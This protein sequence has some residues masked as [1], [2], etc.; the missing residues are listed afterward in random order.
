MKATVPAES[1]SF[2]FIFN[3][4]DALWQSSEPCQVA[5]AP[6]FAMYLFII[7]IAILYSPKCPNYLENEKK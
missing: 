4:I 5:A 2:Y 3:C 1:F 6:S 7:K